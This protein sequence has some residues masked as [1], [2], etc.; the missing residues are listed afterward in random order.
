MP[1]LIYYADADGDDY[2]D[3]DVDSTSCMELTG[4]V[5]DSTDCDDTNSAIYPGATEVCNFLDD[6]CDGYVDDNLVLC[7]CIWMQIMTIMVMQG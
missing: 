5:L 6:D 3:A 2:G 7:G 4:Y 1:S